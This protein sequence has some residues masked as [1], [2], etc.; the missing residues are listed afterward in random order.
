MQ[1]IR[2]LVLGLMMM[3]LVAWVLVIS[4]T[5]A[6]TQT[7]GDL[8]IPLGIFE[9]AAPDGVEAKRSPVEFPHGQHFDI[10]CK[11][12]HHQWDGTDEYLN[13][14]TS[15]CHELTEAPQPPSSDESILYFKKAYHQ[16]C[17]GCHKAI[18]AE[19]LKIEQ[20]VRFNDAET[21]LKN[22]GPTGCVECHPE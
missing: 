3:G 19:N 2:I 17:I 12:C 13:C 15:G 18:K 1:R 11:T 7:E 9:I 5:K 22:T 8:C 20:Q 4:G 21:E 6:W 14:T 10:N 16:Q